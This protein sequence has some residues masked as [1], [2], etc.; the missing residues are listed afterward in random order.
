M[1]IENPKELVEL[2]KDDNTQTQQQEDR[3]QEEEEEKEA[4]KISFLTV[5]F[6]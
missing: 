2:K 1:E 6:V 5:I 3:Q 4:L